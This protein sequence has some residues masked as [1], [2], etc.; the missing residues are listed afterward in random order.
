MNNF[1]LC[2]TCAKP[3]P[4]DAYLEVGDFIDREGARPGMGKRFLGKKFCDLSCLNTYVTGMEIEVM[5]EKVAQPAASPKT[6]YQ[7]RMGFIARFVFGFF[8]AM[9]AA[10][11]IGL[12]SDGD[13]GVPGRVWKVLLRMAAAFG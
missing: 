4:E 7:Q 3:L 8:L 13:S 10:V 6:A 9:L 12:F 1:H 2:S 11:L 5:S